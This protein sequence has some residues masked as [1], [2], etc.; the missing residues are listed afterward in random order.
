M[1]AMYVVMEAGAAATAFISK[2]S[3]AKGARTCAKK[4]Q[5]FITE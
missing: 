3:S 4:Q 2:T 1:K 5:L